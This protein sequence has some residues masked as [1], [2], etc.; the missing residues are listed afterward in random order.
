MNQ[1]CGII[2]NQM[3]FQKLTESTPLTI[4][5]K[6]GCFIVD[7][8]WGEFCDVTNDSVEK[9]FLSRNTAF[10]YWGKENKLHNDTEVIELCLF[11]FWETIFFIYKLL[12]C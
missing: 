2:S 4:P 12:L 3:T 1:I 10:Y 8:E 5:K 7:N 9:R 6:V 11:S